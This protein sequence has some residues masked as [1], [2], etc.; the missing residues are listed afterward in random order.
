MNGLQD[1]GAEKERSAVNKGNLVENLGI[2]K[3]G[4]GREALMQRAES[5]VVHVL[6][7][8][9]FLQSHKGLELF[10]FLEQFS[11]VKK[12]K[13]LLINKYAKK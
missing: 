9:V 1:Y 7:K 8:W 12:I 5:G 4:C 6:A 13:L 2:Q 10:F 11:L 3:T